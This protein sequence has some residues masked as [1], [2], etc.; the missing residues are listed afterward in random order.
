M[1]QGSVA[2]SQ[3]NVLSFYQVQ[4]PEI[5]KLFLVT[6]KRA[7]QVKGV[8]ES[9]EI[10]SIHFTHP[11]RNGATLEIIGQIRQ[12]FDDTNLDAINAL[13]AQLAR[14]VHD[15]DERPHRAVDRDGPDEVPLP[16]RIV[17]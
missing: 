14:G 4:S 8:G 9:D 11:G 13:L 2:V 3:D 15:L 17:S 12:P 5:G 7:R 16:Q 10:T 1:G 6:R